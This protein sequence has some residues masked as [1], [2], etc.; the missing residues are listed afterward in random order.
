MF[1]RRNFSR[2]FVC[3]P[4]TS[5]STRVTP[6]VV[7]QPGSSLPPHAGLHSTIDARAPEKTGGKCDLF[8]QARRFHLFSAVVDQPGSSLLTWIQS[9]ASSLGSS[10]EIGNSTR[11]RASFWFRSSPNQNCNELIKPPVSLPPH[12]KAVVFFLSLAAAS[13]HF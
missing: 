7:D 10:E 3:Q 4:L 2:E 5:S 9:N 12:Q 11:L 1:T 13:Y 6:S 8:W